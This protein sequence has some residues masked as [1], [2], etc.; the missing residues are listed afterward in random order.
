[1]ASGKH[2]VV[3]VL[4]AL[5]LGGCSDIS[6]A[7]FPPETPAD[8]AA[9]TQAP[10]PAPAPAP[11][12]ASAPAP[13]A[14]TPAPAPTMSVSAAPS[15]A[16]A[17]SGGTIVGQKANQIASD[18]ERLKGTIGQ[19]RALKQQITQQVESDSETYHGTLAAIQ[20]RLQLGTTPG[21]PILTRQWS[22][23]QNEL[24]RIN[25]DVLQMNRLSS[26]VGN[27]ASLAAFMLDSVRAARTLTGGLDEDF[28]RL[29]TLEDD[30]NE[31][32]VSID[33]LLGELATDIQR[34]QEYIATARGDLNVLALAI[35]NGQLYGATLRGSGVTSAPLAPTMVS[36]T[37]RPLVV[38]RFDRPN[39]SYENALYTA[40]KGALERRPN[41][42]FEVVAVSSTGG[43]TGSAA[44]S[45]TSSRRNAESVVRSLTQMGLTQDRVRLSTST[46]PTAGNGEVDVFVR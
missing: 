11:V 16:M 46:S 24:D 39:V 22:E 23:A 29:S 4:A 43:T 37:E 10:A 6:D 33:R 14:Q 15:A 36:A 26:D 18:L 12:S 41:A 7:L 21:N 42:G 34:Q 31:T 40:V 25:S 13:M 28:R 17:P 30:T 20:A 2:Y 8:N 3:T 38:I 35:K 5:A 1:M 19:Q 44:I 32:T 27:D 9:A 45:E